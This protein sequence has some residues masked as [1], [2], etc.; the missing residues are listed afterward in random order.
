MARPRDPQ[1]TSASETGGAAYGRE[2]MLWTPTTAGM[3]KA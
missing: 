2:V 3:L 1:S